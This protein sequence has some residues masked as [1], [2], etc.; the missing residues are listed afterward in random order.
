MSFSFS[1]VAEPEQVDRAPAAGV[2]RG[3]EKTQLFSQSEL[4]PAV[5]SRSSEEKHVV[6]E[7]I[8]QKRVADDRCYGSFGSDG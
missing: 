8:R 7:S 3:F 6:K 2:R 4:Q 5:P 1:N